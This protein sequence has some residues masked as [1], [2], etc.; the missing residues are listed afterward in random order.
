VDL[1]H[2]YPCPPFQ[3]KIFDLSDTRS[4]PIEAF[5]R[6]A[7]EYIEGVRKEKKNILVHC[8]AGMSRSG[9]IVISYLIKKYGISYEEALERVRK[10]RRCVGPNRGFVRQL[11]KLIEEGKWRK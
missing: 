7:F 3:N 10:V 4:Q 5:L 1:S 6:P 11:K 2:P 9:I 8:A